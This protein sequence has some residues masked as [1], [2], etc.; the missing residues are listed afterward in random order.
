MKLSPL[1]STGIKHLKIEGKHYP[2]CIHTRA[3]LFKTNNIVVNMSLKFETY[4]SQI[5]QYV[6]L[7]NV[8]S[9]C[10]AQILHCTDFALQSFSNFLN[11]NASVIGYKVVNSLTSSL[12]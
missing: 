1:L 5:C 3:Q 8:R 10:I 12:S 2:T 9:F 6:L 4:R 7:K 11:K